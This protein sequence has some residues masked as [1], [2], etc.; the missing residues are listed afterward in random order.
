M[1]QRTVPAA[2]QAASHRQGTLRR[3]LRWRADNL[4]EGEGNEAYAYPRSD[5]RSR[6][7]RDEAAAAAGHADL[8]GRDAD[9]GHDAVS[10]AST[11][12]SASAAGNDHLPG[13]HDGA[14]RR[15]LPDAASASAASAA[16]RRTRLVPRGGIF[17]RPVPF[18]AVGSSSST[19]RCA[20][21]CPKVTG[22][23]LRPVEAGCSLL[24]V[25]R[26]SGKSQAMH[27]RDILPTQSSDVEAGFEMECRV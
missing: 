7:L 25:L 13:R 1:R 3:W 22:E 2:E 6:G 14:R 18:R 16:C 9:P 12:A 5:G 27:D 4:S 23:F 19:S 15:D 24:A 21:A 10:A 20:D 8:R 11:A 17:P 26:E